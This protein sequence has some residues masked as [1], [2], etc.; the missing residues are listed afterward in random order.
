MLLQR[1]VMI[2]QS[3]FPSL[4]PAEFSRYMEVYREKGCQQN[5]YAY[6]WRNKDGWRSAYKSAVK[7]SHGQSPAQGD[8]GGMSPFWETL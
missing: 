6:T 5:A 7:P 3:V 8:G 4:Y 1:E 2:L